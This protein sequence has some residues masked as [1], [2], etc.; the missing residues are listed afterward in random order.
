MALA[1]AMIEAE[2]HAVFVNQ[3]SEEVQLIGIVICNTSSE[4]ET[5]TLMAV[6]AGQSANSL[7]TIVDDHLLS[8][9]S[10]YTFAPPLMLGPGDQIMAAASLGGRA[11]ATVSYRKITLNESPGV[12]RSMTPL[13]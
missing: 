2:L 9:H 3:G 11:A 10:S 7:C 5:V 8:P 4:P 13:D 6:P 1:Q 12:L